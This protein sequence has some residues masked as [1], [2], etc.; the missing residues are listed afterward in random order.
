[1]EVFESCR[2]GGVERQVGKKEGIR[3]VW[4]RC[5]R[6]RRRLERMARRRVQLLGWVWP[7]LV[8]STGG[9]RSPGH[10]GHFSCWLR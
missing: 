9:G 7:V 2:E 8:K 3:L 5:R 6:R 10:Q 4:G 1:M